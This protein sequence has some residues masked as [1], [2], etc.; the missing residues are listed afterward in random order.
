MQQLWEKNLAMPLGE[1][2]NE[3]LYASLIKSVKSITKTK[4]DITGSK[5]VYYISSEFLIGKLLR[6]NLLKLGVYDEIKEYLLKQGKNIEDLE[7]MEPEPSL[8]NGGLGRLAAC[9]LDSIA[10][11]G[12]NGCGVSLNY[13]FG[14]FK[15]VFIKNEQHELPNPW[16]DD[17]CWLNKT[18]TSFDIQLGKFKTKSNLYQLD[19]LGAN[20]TKIKLNLFDIAT[21]DESLVTSGINFNKKLINKNLTLFLYPDD[22]DHEGRLLRIYQQY[23]MV[24]NAVQLILLELQQ[25][26]FA[27]RN[28]HQHVVIQIND[29]HP[30]L[31]I[32]ELIHQL[33]LNNIGLDDAIAIVEKTVAYTNH[34]ILSEALEKWP[35]DYLEQVVPHLIGIIKYLNQQVIE[36]YQ[37][38]QINIIQNDIVY[39]AFMAIHYSFSING[40]AQLHTHILKSSELKQF[41]AIYPHKFNNKTNGITFQ[42][43]LFEINPELASYLIELLGPELKNELP[44]LNKLNSY[45]NDEKVLHILQ[46][47]KQTKKNSFVDFL[48]KNYNIKVKRNSIFDVQIKRIHE[49]KRQQLNALYIIHK[50]L[51]IKQ[52][53]IPA[54]PITFIFGGKAAPAYTMAK[55]IIHL[56]L[57]LQQLINNDSQTKAH[58]QLLFLE[59]YNVTLAEKLIPATDI[60]EQISLAS[61]EASGTG[62]MKFMLNG[63]ITLGTRDGANVEI[64]ELVGENNIY[65]FGKDSQEVIDLYKNNGYSARKIYSKD[66]TIKQVVDFIISPAMLA[67]GN[68]NN[69]HSLHQELINKDWFMTLLDFNDYV[70]V[71]EQ[72]FLDYENKDLWSKMALKNIAHASYFSSDRSINEYNEEIWKIKQ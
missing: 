47:I 9:F 60:S 27:L 3:Q 32:P 30:S 41:Y 53:H 6:N 12:I 31:V 14:L 28:L 17:N 15:Q 48:A 51:L 52:G 25:Q 57:C 7:Q 56:I 22:S 70:K 18:E 35:L 20:N 44:L 11:L 66:T 5:K 46:Q 40:V 19:I 26:N 72:M 39:M 16:I 24:S 38:P 68:T 64:C 45:Y 58:I 54:R 29:T 65:I 61:K 23:F 63:A 36:K 49:Y 10:N 13:H 62:N 34:T 59:N 55:H 2:S 42:K 50:Y 69:L 33:T 1:A 37:T 4:E 71:K 8:G 67:V 21:V 43:W